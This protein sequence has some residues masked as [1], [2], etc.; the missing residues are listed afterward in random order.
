MRVCYIFLFLLIHWS[1]SS[2]AQVTVGPDTNPNNSDCFTTTVTFNINGQVNGRNS[3]LY[4]TGS[5]NFEIYWTGAR[6]EMWYDG[7]V[8]MCYSDENTLLPPCS[9]VFPWNTALGCDFKAAPYIGGGG[10]SSSVVPIELVY[11]DVKNNARDIQIV[12]E[13]A[14]EAELRHFL[15]EKSE[16]GYTWKIAGE[17][18]ANGNYWT[19]SRYVFE[20]NDLPDNI[21]KMYYRLSAVEVSGQTE[22]L[23]VRAVE[24][25]GR[26]SMTILP[27][28]FSDQIQIRMS[29]LNSAGPGCRVQ[30]LDMLQRV[31]ADQLLDPSETWIQLDYL[32]AGVYWIALTDDIRTYEYVKAIR[33]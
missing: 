32:P 25:S 31:W 30:V 24:L 4:A 6:W 14:Q 2:T 15:I 26:N 19:G 20:E 5:G 28:P 29:D 23:G 18:P 21:R 7:L 9:S 12:W 8:L 1:I 11:F 3:Y 27:N 17:I 13:T 33:Q 22:R 16:D 10:C